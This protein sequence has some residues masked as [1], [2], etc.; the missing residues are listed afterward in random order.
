MDKSGGPQFHKMER[1]IKVMWFKFEIVKFKKRFLNR[2]PTVNPV[3][4]FMVRG[5]ARNCNEMKLQT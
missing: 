2:F 3:N 5:F 4:L 1:N